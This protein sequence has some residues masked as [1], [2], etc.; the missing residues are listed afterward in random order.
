MKRLF[1][2]RQVSGIVR[3]VVLMALATALV[4]CSRTEMLYEN[5][6][7]LILRWTG[8]LVDAS[9]EQREAWREPFAGVMSD[10]RR[11]LLSPVVEWLNSAEVQVAGHA[12]ASDIQCLM[13][14][15]DQLYRRHAALAVPLGMQ[16]VGELSA[17]QVAHLE[18]E[19]R[20]R[21]EDYRDDY[22]QEDPEERHADRVERYVERLERWSGDLTA[23]QVGMVDDA[24]KQMPDI[25]QDWFAYRQQQQQT[26]V[27]LLKQGASEERL[28]DH[29]HAWWVERAD[30]SPKLLRSSDE[31][32][33]QWSSLTADLFN[34]MDDDQRTT[35]IGN[36]REVRNDLARFVDQSQP[37]VMLADLG[38]KN[39]P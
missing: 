32:R 1:D 21:D 8:E 34:S 23:S 18:D 19:L 39:C 30:Q 16:V 11:Q 5:A 12:T 28:R 6:D 2:I 22:L 33:R 10:H 29:L 20:D 4:A 24:V 3:A 36:L 38:S 7:W 15:A 14:S 9:D 25:A 31:F 37:T 13:D 26:L 17:D 35:L 27:R